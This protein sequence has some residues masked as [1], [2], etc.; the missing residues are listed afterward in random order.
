MTTTNENASR[1]ITPRRVGEGKGWVYAGVAAGLAGIASIVGSSFAGAVYDKDVA[2][3]AG[4][5]TQRLSEQTAPI[6]VFH[7]G[8]MVSA[9]LLLAFAAGLRRRLARV[10]PTDSLIPQVATSGLLLVS[11]ALL[12]GSAL[13][14][15]FVF[16]VKDPDLLV[17]QTAAMFG[18]WIGTVPWLW[19]GA[20]VAAI[21][22][23]LA[24]RR[25]AATSGWLA[26]VSL[27]LG[28]LTT[29]FAISP[30]QYMSG[31]TGPLWLTVAA[32]GLLK[33]P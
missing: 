28:G 11:V 17:P 10:V 33:K 7:T 14:T 29:L 27:V 19:G 5:I 20:G 13:T 15:E 4:A 26:W 3:D 32:I 8:A 24:G 1:A 30:L 22:L 9:L 18:H 6:L 21:A 31:M 23:G 16:G 2:G 12:M 25:Y